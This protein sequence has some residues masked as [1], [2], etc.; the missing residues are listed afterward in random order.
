MSAAY[1]TLP[2]GLVMTRQLHSKL[3]KYLLTS[4]LEAKINARKAEGLEG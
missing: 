4:A 3:Y 2:L 1:H